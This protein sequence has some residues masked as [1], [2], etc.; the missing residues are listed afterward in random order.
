[1]ET[2]SRL[3][4]NSRALE[5]RRNVF[6][7]GVV[8]VSL[9]FG[10]FLRVYLI[11]A[12]SFWLDESDSANL[13]KEGYLQ[14]FSKS[15]NTANNP[16]YVY[17]LKSWS[18]IF[19]NSEI[20][21]RS[22]S[23]VCALLSIAAIYFLAKKI[24][25]RKS[26]L[27]AAFILSGNFFSVFYSVEARQYSLAILASICSAYFFSKLV[28][29]RQKKRDYFIYCAFSILGIHLHPWFVLILASQVISTLVF[30]K[31]YRELLLSQAA[32][33]VLSVPWVI[34]LFKIRDSGANEWIGT[35]GIGTIFETFR[36]FFWGNGFSYFIAIG[37]ALFFYFFAVD[38]TKINGTVK[39]VLEER[40]RGRLP[41]EKITFALIYLIF[42]LLAALIISQFFPFYSAGRYEAVVL[43]AFVMLLAFVFSKIESFYAAAA[44][45][46]I[47]AFTSWQAV[48]YERE[49]V[50]SYG[51]NDK[52]IAEDV[53]K[54]IEN[55]DIIVFTGITRPPFDY[56]FSR[57]DLHNK[58]IREISFPS[59]MEVH[60]A[61]QNS[62]DF[63][64]RPENAE[65]ETNEIIREARA[66][67]AK[68]I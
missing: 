53:L 49:K 28:W 57:L 47:I 12:R 52:T 68:N 9:L 60:P 46:G 56:Y 26:G 66:K 42:P 63:S 64:L 51:S 15:I 40:K 11:G 21:L 29:G 23:L 16:A 19:G 54:K 18:A 10:F 1:M 55:N 17:L 27:W 43:P 67:E 62:K 25:D 13:L 22:F 31:K 59:G 24:F 6:K 65:K 50:L 45:G 32:V 38:S 44:I 20:G 7:I 2:I 33:A 37:I 39:Y 3:S 30:G 41:A 34:I 61:Y 48:A 36:S 8:A 58:N 14:L 5:A 4:N 35:A